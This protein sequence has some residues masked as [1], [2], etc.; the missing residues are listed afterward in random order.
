MSTASFQELHAPK[1]TSTIAQSFLMETPHAIMVN[2][3]SSTRKVGHVTLPMIA[4][5]RPSSAVVQR[6]RM[7]FDD[8]QNSHVPI[9]AQSHR[10]CQKEDLAMPPV[11]AKKYGTQNRKLSSMV[12]ATMVPVRLLSQKLGLALAILIVGRPERI[13]ES[14]GVLT[15]NVYAPQSQS[16]GNFLPPQR[17]VHAPRAMDVQVDWSCSVNLDCGTDPGWCCSKPDPSFPKSA[18][19]CTRTFSECPVPP[20]YKRWDLPDYCYAIQDE[21]PS[22][23]FNPRIARSCNKPGQIA[24]TFDDGPYLYEGRL[25]EILNRNNIPATFFINGDNYGDILSKKT[26]E[27]VF[28]I[29]KDGVHEIGDHT[30]S[31]TDMVLEVKSDTEMR[32]QI[33][34]TQDAIYNITGWRPRF[35]RPP[36]GSF[37][38]NTPMMKYL[39]EKNMVNVLWSA[40]TLDATEVVS[41]NSITGFSVYKRFLTNCTASDTSFITLQHSTIASTSLNATMIDSISALARSKG[42]TF[43]KLSECLGEAP[44][45]NAA[46]GPVMGKITVD[47]T[48]PGLCHGGQVGQSCWSD[49]ECSGD[50]NCAK[51]L[52]PMDGVVKGV[53]SL[54]ELGSDCYIDDQCIGDTVCAMNMLTQKGV[55][56]S[57]L[58]NGVCFSSNT[59]LDFVEKG[60]TVSLCC[61]CKTTVINPVTKLSECVTASKNDSGTCSRTCDSNEFGEFVQ[62]GFS[63]FTMYW[64]TAESDF[65][66]ADTIANASL[67][68]LKTCN[69]DLLYNQGLDFAVS[70][71]LEGTALLNDGRILNIEICPSCKTD[72]T[73]SDAF[74]CFFTID[75]DRFPYGIGSNIEST[76]TSWPLHP[77][78]SIASNDLSSKIPASS[79]IRTFF[80]PELKGIRVP[81]GDGKEYIHNGCVRLDDVGWSLSA[82]H[83]DWF[84]FKRETY[85]RLG[86][87]DSSQLGEVGAI[88]T[89]KAPANCTVLTYGFPV[90]AGGTNPKFTEDGS[91]T[92]EPAEDDFSD[93]VWPWEWQGLDVSTF[94]FTDFDTEDYGDLSYIFANNHA[95]L[96]QQYNVQEKLSDQYWQDKDISNPGFPDILSDMSQATMQP[97][98]GTPDPIYPFQRLQIFW[99]Y[100]TD[101]YNG[102]RE[103][104]SS[105]D[106]KEAFH[107]NVRRVLLDKKRNELEKWIFANA[108]KFFSCS[109]GGPA[110]KDIDKPADSCLQWCITSPWGGP[111]F[112]HE[113]N[114]TWHVRDEDAFYKTMSTDLGMSPDL[115][116]LKREYV[117]FNGLQ[118]P[119]PA[120]YQGSEMLSIGIPVVSEA[121]YPTHFAPIIQQFLDAGP[122]K[123]MDAANSIAMMPRLDIFSKDY[124]TLA[125]QTD[126]LFILV[127]NLLNL[128]QNWWTSKNIDKK[129]QDLK[130]MNRFNKERQA[131]I[132]VILSVVFLAAGEL[133]APAVEMASAT[134]QA[135]FR[136]SVQSLRSVEGTVEGEIS[137]AIS[138]LDAGEV[139]AAANILRSSKTWLES[140]KAF[141][142]LREIF[143]PITLK[144][145]CIA[146]DVAWNFGST[147]IP[148]SA[149]LKRRESFGKDNLLWNRADLLSHA[150]E[151]RAP[152]QPN[153]DKL[154]GPNRKPTKSGAD[155]LASIFNFNGKDYKNQGITDI[156]KNPKFLQISRDP[157]NPAPVLED[158][159]NPT[160]VFDIEH[161]V[162]KDGIYKKH[163][164]P[165]DEFFK[166]LS[167]PEQETFKSIIE[168][169]T[170]TLNGKTGNYADH[171]GE[172]VNGSNNLDKLD[173]YAN[174]LKKQI[175]ERDGEILN[176]KAQTYTNGNTAACLDK[177]HTSVENRMP[178]Q[179]DYLDANKNEVL[180]ILE[181][182]STFGS[183]F[184]SFKTS[185]GVSIGDAL[186]SGHSELVQLYQKGGKLSKGVKGFLAK[187]KNVAPSNAIMKKIGD[188]LT[189]RKPKG[190][191]SKGIVKKCT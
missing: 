63:A 72:S 31:H 17:T 22:D 90:A 83:V 139:S 145:A 76:N 166:S 64:I 88:K 33:D 172:I 54:G 163:V 125:L 89:P 159:K 149:A 44:Y 19:H 79:K 86:E 136:G 34:T 174:T 143:K 87:T 99:F 115:I 43:V 124:H 14:L 46:Q 131:I 25:M 35:F 24:M 137:A 47:C 49:D 144:S 173:P 32:L 15:S 58:E 162:E 141:T 176:I 93:T 105:L 113:C 114:E 122:P 70:A 98:A 65:P 179:L 6:I 132:D 42:F 28:N 11:F 107:D 41:N 117:V 167:P 27:V 82:K 75:A 188:I 50:L 68:P 91:S 180:R 187:F 175:V 81:G 37:Q 52:N 29:I 123:F 164:K 48:K 23:N 92:S 59:C 148:D 190:K 39:K 40:D 112:K 153:V 84:V 78:V 77:F 186:A 150:L 21:G 169:A 71:R 133:I 12:I 168:K 2:A 146:A 94:D 155:L 106:D 142:K 184:K 85:R 97:L 26:Q 152:P 183:K 160:S 161:I 120:G 5:T 185:S 8:A 135:I 129:I 178:S 20:K 7:E 182:D 119:P 100:L 177:Y 16:S 165:I 53:C 61:A 121:N 130:L 10:P 67:I 103:K 30:W 171:V 38:L 156:S 66:S 60:A 4:V 56:S 110:T 13:V 191:V 104:W 101:L 127:S 102:L 55:C 108:D 18:R 9:S 62:P 128:Y 109:H 134:V 57:G 80:I 118:K 3:P 170:Y 151:R 96:V 95:S 189:Q 157:K 111:G 73:A 45:Q 140:R 74:G 138:A 51:P 126:S 181:S 147:F 116:D 158:A 36:Y 69:G 1:T 154:F